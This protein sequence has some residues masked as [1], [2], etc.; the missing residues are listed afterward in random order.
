MTSSGP[1]AA[2][3]K[4][5]FAL[6]WNV[7]AFPKCPNP[8]VDPE[9]GKVTGQVCHIRARSREGP[10]FD[11]AQHDA[12]RNEYSNLILMCPIHHSVIDAD[13]EAYTVERLQNLKR[14]QEHVGEWEPPPQLEDRFLAG[15]A[16]SNQANRSVVTSHGQS[17]GQTAASIVNVNGMP[18]AEERKAQKIRAWI[19]Q[20]VTVAHMNIGHFAVLT[21]AVRGYAEAVVVECDD[22]CVTLKIG[23]AT[24]AISLTRV[25]IS[26]DPRKQR[27]Q[28]EIKP[29]G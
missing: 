10:R 17:G 12:D 5:L 6:S 4:R 28:L 23:E 25:A 27:P 20:T 1:T 21:G 11:A 26:R 7:C 24:N 8:L 3:L 15:I 19:G 13:V 18:S 29:A 9:S 16:I 22:D 2:T 14:A